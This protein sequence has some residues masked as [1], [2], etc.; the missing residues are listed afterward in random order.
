MPGRKQTIWA[1]RV[2]VQKNLVSFI[3]AIQISSAISPHIV[4]KIVT[5][6]SNLRPMHLGQRDTIA[7]EHFYQTAKQRQA[8]IIKATTTDNQ[9]SNGITGLRI[10]QFLILNNQ[11]NMP[12]QLASV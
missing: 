3:A 4:D 10:E 8:Q 1:M 12:A 5:C 9:F 7:S 2:I 6:I 11:V